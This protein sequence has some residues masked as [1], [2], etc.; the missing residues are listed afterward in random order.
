MRLRKCFLNEILNN[1]NAIQHCVNRPFALESVSR[2][3]TAVQGQTGGYTC[4]LAGIEIKKIE[5]VYE[6]RTY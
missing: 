3:E 2:R 1:K 5:Y 4:S 6:A